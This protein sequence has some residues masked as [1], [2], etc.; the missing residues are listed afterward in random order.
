MAPIPPTRVASEV[1][2]DSKYS[3]PYEVNRLKILESLI[4]QANGGRALDL[5]C[6]SGIISRYLSAKE[7]SVTAVDLDP[8]NA[9]R[10]RSRVEHAIHGEVV[11]VCRGL[12]EASFDLVCA[13]E[14]IE[15]LTLED[16]EELMREC[17][18]LCGNGMLL[19]STPNRWSPE[20]LYGYYYG[21]KI[22]KK[23]WKAWDGTHQVIYSSREFLTALKRNGWSPREV[24]GYYYSGAWR[25]SL[26]ISS[27]RNWP[28]NRFG[29]NTI[30]RAQAQ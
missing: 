20:G 26:P 2:L 23:R 30:V 10:A 24:I 8:G 7:W 13:F 14:L 1:V 25:F 16:R 17:R 4:P 18:R 9:E 21:E 3:N 28:M 19:I 29:F 15:H 6:G 5:G 11:S 27:S 12:P 22:L